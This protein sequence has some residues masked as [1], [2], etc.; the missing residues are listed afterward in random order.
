MIPGMDDVLAPDMQKILAFL[1]PAIVTLS[2]IT[3]N[4]SRGWSTAGISFTVLFA[5]IALYFLPAMM[6][7]F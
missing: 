1:I 2:L 6:E 5:A 3:M 4:S 7:V